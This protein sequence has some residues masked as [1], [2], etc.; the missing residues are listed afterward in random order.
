MK[1]PDASTHRA[2][3]TTRNI[4]V[5]SGLPIETS[6]PILEPYSDYQHRP[7]GEYARVSIQALAM[8]TSRDIIKPLITS[9]AF[10]SFFLLKVYHDVLTCGSG[11]ERRLTYVS[12]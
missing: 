10:V 11:L 1:K 6:S 4:K 7:P 9:Y 5:V 3:L 2:V 8:I 12:L